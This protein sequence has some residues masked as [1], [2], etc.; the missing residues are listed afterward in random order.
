MHVPALL[1]MWNAREAKKEKSSKANIEEKL[2]FQK[3]KKIGWYDRENKK[4][5]G[6]K[7]ERERGRQMVLTKEKKQLPWEG[8]VGGE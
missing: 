7:R 3:T 5:Y 8:E 4:Y 6:K 2:I 1:Q